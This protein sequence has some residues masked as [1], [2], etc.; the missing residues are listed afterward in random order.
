MLGVVKTARGEGNVELREVPE[1]SAGPGEV[2][3]SVRNAG[4]CG[5]DIHI[6]RNHYTFNPPVVLGHEFC[7]EIAEVGKGVADLSPGDRVTCETTAGSCGLCGY[8]RRGNYNLC[9]ERLGIGSILN[10]AFTRYVIAP[11]RIVHRLPENIDFVAG[12][13]TE[14]VACAVHGVIH[15]TGVKA[16]EVT[17]VAG[18]GP[19]GLITAQVAQAEG[20]YVILLGRD[21]DISRLEIAQKLDLPKVI[22][23]DEEDAEAFVSDLT[24]GV[25]ADVVFECAGAPSAARMLLNLVRKAGRYSQVGLMSTPFEIDWEQIAYKELQVLGTFSQNWRDWGRALELMSQGKVDASAI[26]SRQASIMEWESSFANFEAAKEV[27]VLLQP[28]GD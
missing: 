25:G 5:T 8:C 20:A 28:V 16:G 18:P 9:N 7:G 22:N 4:I 19:I 24:G 6:F 14:P 13:L 10:G 17:V 23:I 1:P 15:I 2:K 26:V 3:I 27:K 12:A 21:L 11:R